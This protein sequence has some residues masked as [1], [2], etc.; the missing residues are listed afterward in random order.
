MH[1]KIM[2]DCQNS[3]GDLATHLGSRGKD[4]GTRG[5]SQAISE[6]EQFEADLVS[7][8]KDRTAAKAAV[9]EA[10]AIRKKGKSGYDMDWQSL[11]VTGRR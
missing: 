8:K 2:S 6:Q 7:P 1:K 5:G 4:T 11:K 9:A 3:G 10:T